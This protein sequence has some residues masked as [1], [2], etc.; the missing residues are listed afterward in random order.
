MPELLN[1]IILLINS[2]VCLSYADGNG[3]MVV[4]IGQYK[5]AF[6]RMWLA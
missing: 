5:C 1:D 6:S 3:A 2:Y 4:S